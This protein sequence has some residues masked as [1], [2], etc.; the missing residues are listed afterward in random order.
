[1]E[2]TLNVAKALYTMYYNMTGEYMDEMRMHKLMYFSQREAL[3]NDNEPL[4]D[5]DFYGWKYGP[6]LKE[7][8]SAYH[9]DEF[10]VE[11]QC[12]VE[13]NTKKILKAVINRYSAMSSWKLSSLSHGEFS[14]KKARQ[15]LKY[16][17]N[18]DVKLLIDAIRV[19][20][21]LEK[22]NRRKDERLKQL[23]AQKAKE[24]KAEEKCYD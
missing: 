17:D 1:M 6:V 5:G 3:M 20:A 8:R 7:V 10:C 2:K 12:C 11:S 24:K 4:F 16:D 19:D 23:K 14:W 18:G 9:N 13:D 15:G 21:V 22:V